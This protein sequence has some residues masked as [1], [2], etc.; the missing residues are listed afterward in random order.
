M[1]LLDY[2]KDPEFKKSLESFVIVEYR[3]I[4]SGE[5]YRGNVLTFDW[6][7]ETIT[8]LL[9]TFPFELVVVSTQFADYPQELALRFKV[10]EVTETKGRSSYMFI[11]DEE[12]ARDI[13]AFLSLLC[14]RLITVAAKVRES[15][16]HEMNDYPEIFRD[17]PVAF[18]G[19]LKLTSWQRHQ[20]S[21]VYGAK[22]IEKII[23]Y[24]PQPKPV[25]PD[26]LKKMF[27][28]L[29][30]LDHA[31]SIVLS[32]RRYALALELIQNRP[33]LSYQFLISSIETI[34]N[35][36]CSSFK[37]SEDEMVKV[38]RPVFKLALKF[39]L[40]EPE[41]KQL[42]IEACKRDSWINRKFRKFLCDYVGDE[43]WTKKDD[44][45]IDMSFLI[46]K[47]E[48][49]EYALKTIYTN[50]GKN[51]HAGKDYPIS[52]TV[53][54]SPFMPANIML[55]TDT[56]DLFPPVTWFERAVNIALR[57]YL[58]RSAGLPLGVENNRKKVK[59][60]RKK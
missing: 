17:W 51:L 30:N 1:Y 42:A 19:S 26:Y 7:K 54:T 5:L 31:E 11:P 20:S 18:T 43:L 16:P 59:G 15:H 36:V 46:P 4:C 2:L 52:A 6:R 34:A 56:K 8:R 55:E 44:V 50:R 25:D 9:L 35:R 57:T 37:P 60:K 3:L 39:G 33:E 22:G 38:K 28:A 53:G 32:A 12:I 45:F 41:A 49:F 29:P 24:N 40:S 10:R 27:L 47:R 23:D 58:E 48:R 14:R 21:V 13:A